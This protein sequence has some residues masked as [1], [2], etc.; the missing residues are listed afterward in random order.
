[1]DSSDLHLRTMNGLKGK[2]GSHGQR[3]TPELLLGKRGGARRSGPTGGA[4]KR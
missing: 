1:M 4:F 2:T 3:V